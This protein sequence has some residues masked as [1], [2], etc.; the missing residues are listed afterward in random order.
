MS[1]EEAAANTFTGHMLSQYGITEVT[2]D[3]GSFVGEYGNYTNVELRFSRPV[4]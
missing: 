3:Q 4:G 1:Y 2:I